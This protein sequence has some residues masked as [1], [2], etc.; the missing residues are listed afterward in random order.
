MTTSRLLQ[1]LSIKEKSIFY[2]I[3]ECSFVL[4]LVLTDTRCVFCYCFE[5]LRARFH[6]IWYFT[7]FASLIQPETVQR[8]LRLYEEITQP[9]LKY[10]R[11]VSSLFVYACL[12]V[13]VRLHIC[14]CAHMCVYL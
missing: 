1:F 11:Y 13:F 10:Y 3:S 4:A 5:K 14:M 2:E 9:L 8:R 6:F 7:S 12:Y